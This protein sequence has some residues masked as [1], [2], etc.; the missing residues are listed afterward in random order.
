MDALIGHLGQPFQDEDLIFR[1]AL[2]GVKKDPPRCG[3]LSVYL[4]RTDRQS[5]CLCVCVSACLR[6]CVSVYFP[7]DSVT[8]TTS[9]SPLSST[10]GD[11]A[12]T[13]S[14]SSSR[15]LWAPSTSAACAPIWPAPTCRACAACCVHCDAGWAV[16]S[17]ALGGWSPQGAVLH[18][19]ESER[20]GGG[21]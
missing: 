18:P 13:P 3:P 8:M 2:Y 20:Q 16:A 12:C 1:R 17:Q 10:G 11:C 19:C 14:T 6:V 5:A 7:N 21:V 9:L 15:T 4:F